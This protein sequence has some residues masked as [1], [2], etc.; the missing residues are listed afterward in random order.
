MPTS[1]LDRSAD[2]ANTVSSHVVG[3]M[4]E[5]AL[6]AGADKE[7]IARLLGVDPALLFDDSVRLPTL[8]VTRLWEL[9]YQL[10]GP[11]AGVLAA[12]RAERGRLNVW[13]YLIG[14]APT[15]AEGLRDAAR[16]NNA[17]C[18]RRVDLEV[19]EDG[20]LLTARYV[21][22]PHKGAAGDANKEFVMA[23]LVRRATESFGAAGRPVRVDF[24][25]RAPEDRAYLVRAL[26]TGNIHFGQGRDAI[27]FLTSPAD[28][29]RSNDPVLQGIL[30]SHAQQV[31]DSIAPEPAWLDAF[32]AALHATLP[33]AG[34]EGRRLEEVASSLRISD[35]TLQR[36]L[37]EH[38]TSWRAELET[39]RRET[40]IALLRDST[41]P[42]RVV[43][44]RL[45]YRDHR[46]LARAFRRW[47]GQ[48]PAGFR[49]TLSE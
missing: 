3:V 25:H 45:G 14:S 49:R 15:L 17:I 38:G 21:E 10:A 6:R 24:S 20:S 13:D 11:E 36:R 26:G 31:I 48:S 40:A 18:D 39:L 42:V 19:V 32:R 1:I 8:T 12:G 41:V 35:R 27:T 2:A 46:V 34:G 4:V 33:S 37:A 9:L 30:R 44:L 29:Q 47:T 5:A 43:A 22:L 23:V 28:S 7:R 16:Y